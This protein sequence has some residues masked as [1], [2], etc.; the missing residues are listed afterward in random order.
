MIG[1]YLADL[2]VEGVLIIELKT[3]KNLA[4]EHEAQILGYLKFARLEHGLLIKILAL[5]NLKSA[6]LRGRKINHKK[7][8]EYQASSAFSSLRSLRSLRLNKQLTKP[9]D[10]GHS[11]WAL[12][13]VWLPTLSRSLITLERES[14]DTTG[15]LVRM[16]CRRIC[17]HKHTR[18]LKGFRLALG[19][20]D[21]DKLG[22]Q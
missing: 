12:L 21:C 18:A 4:P 10:F 17:T 19:D 16:F 13:L 1:D 5:T 7:R 2:L 15:I 3:A 14:G 20:K 9:R 22:R 11:S 8:R 6:S